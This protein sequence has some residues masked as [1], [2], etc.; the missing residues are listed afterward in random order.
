MKFFKKVRAW[1]Q[2]LF[3]NIKKF[4]KENVAPAIKFVNAVKAVVD[5]PSLDFLVA[6]SATKLDD[7]ILAGLRQALSKAIDIMEVQLECGS[8]GTDLE[9][10]LCYINW[11][12]SL[13]LEQRKAMYHK[14]ASLI[15]RI[16]GGTEVL[17]ASEVDLL[18]QLEYSE[19]KSQEA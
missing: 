1:F 18:V 10:I 7:K 13:P 16:K 19:S 8:K 17:R 5:N 6:L 2:R 4:L 11:L 14:T 3:V 12:R 15:A 9:K